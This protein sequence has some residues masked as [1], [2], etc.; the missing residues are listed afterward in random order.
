[1]FITALT[2]ALTVSQHDRFLRR[3]L[4]APRPTP[5]LEDHPLPAF[6][7]CLFN[8]FAATLHIV[9]HSSIRNLRT[10]HA[11]A[12]ETHLS[13]KLLQINSGTA[14]PVFQNTPRSIKPSRWFWPVMTACCAYSR[15]RQCLNF[16]A[17]LRLSF[18]PPCYILWVTKR[19]VLVEARSLSYSEENTRWHRST[20]DHWNTWEN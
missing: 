16:F 9:G 10:R 4:L 11:V 15:I 6:P 2:S 19:L 13:S 20:R 1:M 7:D 5:K 14:L 12:T 3:E 8:I 18:D 17:P